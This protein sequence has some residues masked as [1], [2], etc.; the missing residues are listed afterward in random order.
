LT[1]QK[2][3]Q[4]STGGT[5]FDYFEAHNTHKTGVLVTKRKTGSNL[6]GI[7]LAKCFACLE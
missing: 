5:N 6:K 1:I 2:L 3:N 7:S 4:F